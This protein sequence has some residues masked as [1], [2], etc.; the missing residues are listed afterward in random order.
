MC[1]NIRNAERRSKR[2]KARVMGLTDLDLSEV[3]HARA[4]KACIDMGKRQAAAA[5]ASA[6]SRSS[7]SPTAAELQRASSR[8][9]L[10]ETGLETPPRTDKK[11]RSGEESME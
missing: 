1:E 5:K 10:G 2:L 4:E 11:S 6:K 3:L 8:A 7:R 9:D